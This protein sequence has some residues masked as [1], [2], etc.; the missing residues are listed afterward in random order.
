MPH[1][2]VSTVDFIV[3]LGYYLIA[4]MMIVWVQARWPETKVGEA[5]AVLG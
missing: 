5:L 4:K 1:I 2:H 3:F